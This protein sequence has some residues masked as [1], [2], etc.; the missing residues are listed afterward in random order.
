MRRLILEGPSL[1]SDAPRS[2]PRVQGACE[3]HVKSSIALRISVPIAKEVPPR[4]VGCN[5]F[6]EQE[7]G[8]SSLRW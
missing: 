6:L 4:V 3:C 8:L 7:F 5:S 2:L 1:L